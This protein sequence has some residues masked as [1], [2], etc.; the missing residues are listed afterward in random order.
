MRLNA[1][2]QQVGARPSGQ[3][4][5][6]LGELSARRLR[7][8]SSRATAPARDG[9]TRR[10]LP[11]HHA[12]SFRRHWGKLG[13]GAS[14]EPRCDELGRWHRAFRCRRLRAIRLTSQRC[15]LRATPAR[16]QEPQMIDLY[17]WSTPN[18]RKV[19]IMLEECGLRLRRARRRHQQ[20]RAVQAR[21]PEDQPQQPHPRDRRPRQRP[22]A[23]RVRRDP[24]VPRREDRQVLAQGQG[25]PLAHHGVAD[26]ADGRRR[27]RCSARCTT[28]CSNAKG[29]APY[30]EERYLKEAHRLYGVLD[31]RLAR[32]ASTWPATT[33]SPTWRPGPGSRASSGR[34]VDLNKYPNVLRW[35]KAIAAR[36]AVVKGYHV[37]VKQPGIPMPA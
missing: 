31:R 26:V 5:R 11:Q 2:E 7:G 28:S 24:D 36:P 9:R 23:V 34:P 3:V 18:G 35:Y 37:P 4:R 14:G 30:A 1:W 33:R 22:V 27:A 21:L 8:L 17:T 6:S 10:A 15:S 25:R 12:A 29:K 13:L 16:A 19:S 32:G 20:G